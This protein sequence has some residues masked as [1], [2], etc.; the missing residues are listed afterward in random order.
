MTSGAGTEPPA[1]A[2]ASS[3]SQIASLLSVRPLSASAYWAASSWVR[4]RVRAQVRVRVRV[5]ARH[6]GGEL[7]ELS[8]EVV[9]GECHGRGRRA[10]RTVS[11]VAP[12]R[13]REVSSRRQHHLLVGGSDECV[14]LRQGQLRPCYRKPL[15][16]ER[17]YECVAGRLEPRPR[18]APL[19]GQQE[20]R[21]QRLESDEQHLP[22]ARSPQVDGCRRLHTAP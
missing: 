8:P 15:D 13:P 10:A 19:A 4:V 16:L 21:G 14:Q 2:L 17:R 9:E 22:A 1:A 18:V 7:L 11:L 20:R 12:G 6:G 5:G 3:R